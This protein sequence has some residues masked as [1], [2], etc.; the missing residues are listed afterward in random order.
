MIVAFILCLSYSRVEICT[1]IY[2]RRAILYDLIP[3]SYL[4]KKKRTSL[5]RMSWWCTIWHRSVVI[6]RREDSVKWM[7]SFILQVY[8]KHFR[9]SKSLGIVVVP[10]RHQIKMRLSHMWW[11][12]NYV[13]GF[14]LIRY[15]HEKNIAYRDLKP[16][17][18]V[19]DSKVRTY[20]AVFS[21]TH[22]NCPSTLS[23]I[24]EE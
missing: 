19:L 10:C 24:Y 7:Y 15:I 21:Y 6:D 18:L 1:L 16:E 20:A 5:E 13:I 14:A 3:S 9:K 22:G 17:N 4:K 11:D 2:K 23:S 12:N 8:W